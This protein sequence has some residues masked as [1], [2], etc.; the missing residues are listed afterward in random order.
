MAIPPNTHPV[1]TVS[2]NHGLGRRYGKFDF[3][4][5]CPLKGSVYFL[6]KEKI[7]EMEVA[8]KFLFQQSRWGVL[9]A[10][11]NPGG[12]L[13][14]DLVFTEPPGCNL[15]GA[16]VTLLLD[17]YDNDLKRH[18]STQNRTQTNIPVHVVEH[19]PQNLGGPLK[20]AE[21]VTT[22]QFAPSFRF[23]DLAEMGGMGQT[24]ETRE[25]K[26][27]QWRFSSQTMP[28][29]SGRPTTLIWN[30]CESKLDSQPKHKNTFHTALAFE[31]DGQPF[32]IRVGVKGKLDKTL[33]NIRDKTKKKLRFP[34][35]AQTVTT[36]VDF[37]G[38]ENYT[39]PL[40][41]LVQKIP[42]QMRDANTRPFDQVQM[43]QTPRAGLDGFTTQDENTSAY[44]TAISQRT[45]NVPEDGEMAELKKSALP[46]LGLSGA[47][48]TGRDSYDA[49]IRSR[50]IP[51]PHTSSP[52]FDQGNERFN[53]SSATAFEP[54]NESEQPIIANT[55]PSMS[56]LRKIHDFLKELGVFPALVQLI[57]CLVILR[58]V[59]KNS[60]KTHH[61]S[62]PTEN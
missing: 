46:L 8:C 31:H 23:L 5:F 35:K 39:Q 24:S 28:D 25:N 26:E 44:E 2:R 4:K 58:A 53:D 42:L 38:R 11:R 33:S 62:S 18:F 60:F 16:T 6:G 1:Y 20:T 37:K 27:S 19:G 32:F 14:L 21:K 30:L 54:G 22:R 61:S 47:N 45:T 34:G 50:E 49:Y 41:E 13:Y 36:L 17:E 12:I 9:T 48:N 59:E 10:A 56:G 29:D 52:S 7:G 57:M 55:S 15:R 3:D 51:E 43:P 40:D